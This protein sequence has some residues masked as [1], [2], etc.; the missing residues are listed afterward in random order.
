MMGGNLNKGRRGR[1]IDESPQ[2]NLI[3]GPRVG[4]RNRSLRH[5]HVLAI[6]A[7]LGLACGPARPRPQPVATSGEIERQ[8]AALP[9]S[10][11]PAVTLRREALLRAAGAQERAIAEIEA[12][13]ES[14]RERV[15]LAAMAALWRALGGVYLERGEP[16]AALAAF[17]K[18]LE[19]ARSHGGASLRASALAD[20][21]YAFLLL[22]RIGQADDAVAQAR[23]LGTSALA[24]DPLAS[25]RLGLIA[26]ALGDSAGARDRFA[27]AARGHRQAG[28]TASAA[29]AAV[30]AA[31]VSR[32]VP[33][34]LARLEPEV[35]A[36]ADRG[37]LARLRLQQARLARDGGQD[38][39]CLAA[40]GEALA[41]AEARG[42]RRAIKSA[43]ILLARCAES[44][45]EL[46]AAIEHGS[47]AADIV[48]DQIGSVRGAL[49]RQELGF[50]A[51]QIYRLLVDLEVRR[52]GAPARA[53]YLS[54][55]ARGRAHLD[56]VVHSEVGRYSATLPLPPGLARDR[57]E[58]QERVRRLTDALRA[59]REAEVTA[60]HRDALWAL[61]E[62]NEAIAGE[63]P[64]LS[65]VAAPIPVTAG[66]VRDR[67]LDDDSAL[68]SYFATGERLL[69]FAIDR[70]GEELATVAGSLD[71]I[72]A[73]VAA[74]RAHLL[75]PNSDL[76]ELRDAGASLYRRLLGP[77]ATRLRG[78]R[79]LII[80]PHGS[81]GTLPFE[82]LVGPRR[83]FVVQ[84]HVVHYSVSATLAVAVAEKK[85]RPARLGG[86]RFVGLGDPIYDWPHGSKGISEHRKRM[87]RWRSAAGDD[88]SS[89][90][91]L[92]RIPGTARE[93]RE[94]ARLFGDRARI[95]LRGEAREELVKSGALSKATIVHIASH[96]LMAPHYQALALTLDPNSRED[97]FLM[98]SEIAQLDLEAE[99]VVLS[100]CGTGN[101]RSRSAEPVAGMALS[102]RSAGARSVMLSLWNV[103]D[104]GTADLMVA[105]YRA[106]VGAER[107]YGD[108]LTR[109]KREMLRGERK[110][111]YFWAPFILHG[112]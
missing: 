8:L 43:R 86:A 47:A 81:L 28:D 100:A 22:G 46:A 14:A 1:E 3:G 10:P 39:R 49:A 52:R 83:R 9:A 4:D 98:S 78:K 27:D 50:Q 53:F 63:N 77:V 96:G 75:D 25:E 5:V 67:L 34:H 91:D 42:L 44:A 32:D 59:S 16:E 105:F 60:R 103:S 29:R 21:A 51:F 30:R 36:L 94:I 61:E 68:V 101:T 35:A 58:A 11:E 72:D 88:R 65:R 80:V 18:R 112:P 90:L 111:P 92:K 33:G 106:A 56:A 73:A 13:I 24:E 37:P 108:S 82:S 31:R 26:E 17:G 93:L 89:P 45:G 15:D 85:W 71:D 107:S 64:L 84:D 69:V 79:R 66:R 48:E 12:A 70:R 74:Y 97:G 40:G 76:D 2:A 6:A 57:A 62:I 102:L 99:L 54:E 41:L 38:L 95:Y 20:A 110:H 104:E 23:V 55:R 109:A 7:G 87:R 19:L